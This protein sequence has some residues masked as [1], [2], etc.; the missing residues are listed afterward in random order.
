MSW[1]RG[2]DG[3]NKKCRVNSGVEMSTWVIKKKEMAGKH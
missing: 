3:G 1:A 2:W